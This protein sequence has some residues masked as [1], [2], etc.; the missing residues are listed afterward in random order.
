MEEELIIPF[1]Q[2]TTVKHQLEGTLRKAQSAV[3]QP[4]IPTATLVRGGEYAASSGRT[5]LDLS[6]NSIIVNIS[7]PDV[8]DLVFYD[9]PGSISYSDCRPQN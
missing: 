4:W 7:G 9:L 8:P 5:P 6:A 3:L 2:P 1:G